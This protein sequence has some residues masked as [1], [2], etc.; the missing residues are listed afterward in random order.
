V[1]KAPG[2]GPFGQADEAFLSSHF[3]AGPF[4]FSA[5]RWDAAQRSKESLMADQQQDRGCC[6]T[7][8]SGAE[9]SRWRLREADWAA[10]GADLQGFTPEC[11]RAAAVRAGKAGRLAHGAAA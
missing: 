2:E 1:G 3:L 4:A 7:L 6:P 10:T 11:D 8:D 5:R 9:E